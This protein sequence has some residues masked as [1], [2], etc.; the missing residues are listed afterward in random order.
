[1]DNQRLQRCEKKR[2]FVL[3]SVAVML[4]LSGCGN[5][6]NNANPANNTQPASGMPRI[7]PN[8]PG[9][10]HSGSGQI[11][12]GLKEATNPTYK[13]GS[14]AVINADHMPG[15]KGAAAKIVGAYDTTAYAV[16]YTP[17]T[18]GPKVTNHKWVVHE[19]IKG[20][21]GKP[22]APGSK[23]VLETDHMPGMLGA[24]ATIDSAEH[25]TVYMVDYTPTAGGQ[26]VKY[27]QW[28]TESELSAQ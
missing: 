13:V 12:N 18:G 21:S 15:M 27:H 16:T 14:Q 1:M 7:D 11:P 19:E 5:G 25:T 17:T 4:A 24:K 26:P 9:L 3:L 20:A 23:V 8:M 28:L 10:N 6:N 22:Y 2:H